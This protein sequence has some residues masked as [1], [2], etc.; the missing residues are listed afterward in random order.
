MIFQIIGINSTYGIFQVSYTKSSEFYTSPGSN[1]PSAIGQ[2]ALVSLAGTIGYGLTWSGSIFVNP[3]L[4]KYR[5]GRHI[6]LF[7]VILMSLGLVLASFSTKLVHLFL[8]QALLYGIGAS[9]YYFPLMSLTPLYFDQHRGFA[10]GLV[11]SGS[12]FGGLVFAPVTHALIARVGVRW[13]LRVLGIWN[14]IVG[15]PIALVVRERSGGLGGIRGGGLGLI[16]RGTFFWQ[17]LGAF[18]QAAGNLVPAYYMTTYCTSV[19]NYS[20]TTASLVLA[21]F[22]AVNSVSRVGM[23]VLADKVGRQNTMV[24]SVSISLLSSFSAI[25]QLITLVCSKNI[26]F[27]PSYLPYPS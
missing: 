8:T 2:D 25:L 1:I 15:I 3:C 20:S 5:N 21:L 23:G 13:T 16:M 26:L 11:L 12:G 14:V 17:S 4:R 24:V 6:T 7:G 10:M 27:R 18:L 9:F 19:L 22:N